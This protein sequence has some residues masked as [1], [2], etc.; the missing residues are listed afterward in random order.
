MFKG[1]R[2]QIL[3][4]LRPYFGTQALDEELARLPDKQQEYLLALYGLDGHEQSTA[5]DIASIYG[6]SESVVRSSCD[7]ALLK[8]NNPR[9]LER[10]QN[11]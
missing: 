9:V 8:L 5:R 7:N 6:V 4:K 10:L 2:E 3:D 11:S 1:Q